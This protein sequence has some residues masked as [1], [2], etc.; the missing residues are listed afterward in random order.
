MQKVPLAVHV[1]KFGSSIF[2]SLHIWAIC[3]T[4]TSVHNNNKGKC[5]PKEFT[6]LHWLMVFLKS[7]NGYTLQYHYNASKWAYGSKLIMAY[8]CTV[9][10][11]ASLKKENNN[12]TLHPRLKKWTC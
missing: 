3:L 9:Y 5:M 1:K 10:I 12:Q 2:I 7:A 8:V 6:G 4:Y 11:W